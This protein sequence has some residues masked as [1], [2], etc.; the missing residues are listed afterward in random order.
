M[1]TRSRQDAIVRN[2]RRNGTST[3][4]ALAST[5]GASRSTTIRDIAA[6]R[7]EGFVIQTEPGAA[8]GSA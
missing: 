5:V 1:K 2:L 3:I 4:E 6:L 8:V 7:D